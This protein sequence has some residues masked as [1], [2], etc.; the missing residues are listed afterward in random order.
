MVMVVV[1]RKNFETTIEL[2]ISGRFI[3]TLLAFNDT[4]ADNIQYYIIKIMQY[5]SLVLPLKIKLKT[6]SLNP[7]EEHALLWLFIQLPLVSLSKRHLNKT[8]IN[9]Y[10]FVLVPYLYYITSANRMIVNIVNIIYFYYIIFSR[11]RNDD[12]LGLV[13]ISSK[14]FRGIYIKTTPILRQSNLESSI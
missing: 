7:K 3:S 10:K 11:K 12:L 5:Y 13:K 4:A 9:K 1:R 6:V 14:E 8:P 2:A